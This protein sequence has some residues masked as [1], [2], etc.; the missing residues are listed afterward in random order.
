M[1]PK[2]RRVCQTI[3]GLG[4]VYLGLFMAAVGAFVFYALLQAL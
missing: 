1:T 2:Q 4:M 3:V